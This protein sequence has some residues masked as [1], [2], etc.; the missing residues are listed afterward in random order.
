M[1]K[2]LMVAM[3]TTLL[4]TMVPVQA[5]EKHL[6]WMGDGDKDYWYEH[7]VR[8]GTYG[9]PKNIRDT[10]Y[11]I[12]RGREI[13]DPHS[14]GWYWL[15]AVYG[16][17]KAV[18]KEVWMPYVFQEDF[19]KG[20]NKQGKWVRYNQYGKMIKGWYT[21]VG[22]DMILYTP[23]IGNVYYYDLITGAMAKGW[24][25]IDGSQ[26]HFDETTGVLDNFGKEIKPPVSLEEFLN[27]FIQGYGYSTGPLIYS[28]ANPMLNTELITRSLIA[29]FLSCV[30]YTVGPQSFNVEEIDGPD[31]RGWFTAHKK[32]DAEKIDWLREN[33][34]NMSAFDFDTFMAIAEDFG[35]CYKHEFT[36]GP[37]YI[38]EFGI[39]GL[40]EPM[41]SIA[42]TKIKA[43]GNIYFV[44]YDLYE[45]EVDQNTYDWVK[46]KKPYG[47]YHAVLWRKYF[48]QS[49]Y[50]S[51]IANGELPKG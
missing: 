3:T 51:I 24:I 1:R 37:C 6:V 9:D 33:V 49:P 15:D 4:M 36:D 42:F 29:P 26:Y 19:E 45:W 35:E 17:A 11:G 12:E 44:E 47:S 40:E 46:K 23:Q 10:L 16:G 7:D 13:Y 5:E 28:S 31:P 2:T 27:Q 38:C 41:N 30:N 34:L 43:A 39:Y 48:N 18:D 20:I 22:N 25:E 32:Y 50:W 21:P 14:D 8:Q